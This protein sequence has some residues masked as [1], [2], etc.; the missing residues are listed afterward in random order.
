MNVSRAPEAHIAGPNDQEAVSVRHHR[1]D[2]RKGQVWTRRQR[3]KNDLVWLSAMAALALV[4]MVPRRW[5]PAAGRR[6][7]LLLH[8]LLASA[9]HRA[10]CNVALCHPDWTDRQCADF[11]RDNFSTLGEDLADT[12]A[13]LDP[14]EPADRTIELPASSS[15][16]LAEALSRGKG[17]VYITA[18]L[19]PWERMAAVLAARGF[20]ISTVAR[21]SYDPRFDALY[22]RLRRPR[23]VDALYRGREGV[24]VAIVRALRNNRV[25]GFPIDL[26]GR[27]PT[28]PVELLGQA[29]KLP[30][31]PARI[32]LR[33]GAPIVVGTPAPGPDGKLR[34]HIAPL[35]T[36]GLASGAS[37]ESSLAQL[38]A[39]AL[40]ERIRAL[41]HHWIWMHP[42]FSTD[43]PCRHCYSPKRNDRL[44]SPP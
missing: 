28:V 22:D 43:G 3:V 12:V 15:R 11:V 44:A 34:I 33:T 42:S 39:D 25:V 9:R 18:H 41:P 14:R 17:V 29:S 8:R 27:I 23:G 4:R 30:I 32:A 19:G 36:E 38:M 26:P 5:L 37:G 40:S 10:N 31:G 6:L 21:E 16:V 1:N 7:G 20:P 2:V 13:L 35:D 24:P